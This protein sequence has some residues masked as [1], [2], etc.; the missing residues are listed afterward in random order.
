MSGNAG[1]AAALAPAGGDNLPLVDFDKVWAQTSAIFLQ[2]Q[3]PSGL[4]RTNL[5]K[6]PVVIS[7]GLN[8][9]AM[10]T[11]FDREIATN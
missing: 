11:G 2:S 9:V 5:P 8:C 10:H 3:D 1:N 4:F 6:L 7:N